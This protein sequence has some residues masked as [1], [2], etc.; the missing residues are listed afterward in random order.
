MRKGMLGI[1]FVAFVMLV[2]AW[3]S[4]EAKAASRIE[5]NHISRQYAPPPMGRKEGLLAISNR[6]WQDYT[7]VI[8]DKGRMS[9]Y[10]G[11]TTYA[12]YRNYR[13]PAG[14]T[15]YMALEKDTWR[16]N[17]ENT[18]RLRVKIREGRTSTL[19]LNPF[20]YVGNT[21]LMGVTND[22]DKV[23]E[24]VLFDSY[25]QPVVVRPPTIVAP[26]PPPTIIARPPV[27]VQRPPVVVHRPPPPPPPRRHYRDDSWG[28]SFGFNSGW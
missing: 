19:S 7:L 26:P 1:G 12:G 10:R 4:P 8:T 21:G 28:F 5:L 24:E 20:G 6:D 11:D 22:G 27:I 13:L 9:L 2:M 3:A 15:V 23:R 18:D 14:S 17:A 25:T 16:I